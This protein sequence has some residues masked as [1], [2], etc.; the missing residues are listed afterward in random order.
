M[1]PLPCSG[2]E[3]TLCVCV[4]NEIALLIN[5]KD[6]LKYKY[7]NYFINNIKNTLKGTLIIIKNTIYPNKKYVITGAQL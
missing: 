4:C 1:L 7:E 5:H 3:T 2:S 6:V